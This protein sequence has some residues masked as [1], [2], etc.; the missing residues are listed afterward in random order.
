MTTALLKQALEAIE[1]LRYSAS[2]FNAQEMS[3]A[4]ITAIKKHLGEV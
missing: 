1:E 2:T 4:A 3:Q